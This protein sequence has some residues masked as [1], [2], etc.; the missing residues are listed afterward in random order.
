MK[1]EIHPNT[2]KRRSPVRH[3]VRKCTTHATVPQIRMT[4]APIATRFTPA[5]S[6]SWTRLVASNAS[7]SAATQSEKAQKKSPKR[8]QKAR[9]KLCGLKF[10]RHRL[11]NW[12]Q[13]KARLLNGNRRSCRVNSRHERAANAD[14][15]LTAAPPS[16]GDACRV[17]WCGKSGAKAISS[18]RTGTYR[19]RNDALASLYSAS[20]RRAD[21]RIETRVERFHS[22]LERSPLLRLPLVRGVVSWLK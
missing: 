20:V 15:V 6:A 7:I 22:V 19:G 3:V 9:E 4:C 21:G 5:S 17:S 8:S 16:E 2:S 1:A 10:Q 13:A 12:L 18:R 11:L 14:R